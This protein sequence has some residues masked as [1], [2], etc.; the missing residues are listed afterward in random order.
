MK[1]LI[2]VAI[3]SIALVSAP[4]VSAQAFSTTPGT[5][6][7]DST[8]VDVQKGGG[9]Q[10]TCNL[11]ID[12]TR[13]ALGNVTAG[14]PVMTGGFF[15]L[16]TTVVFQNTPWTV[17]N[18]GPNVWRLSGIYVDTT[19]TAGDC[20]GYLDATFAIIGGKETLSVDTGF[21]PPPPPAAPSTLPEVDPGTG[22]CKIRGILDN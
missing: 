6:T 3:A 10:L 15:N 16:C 11:S 1:K 19:V 4:S 2:S 8:N 14:N 7:F 21:T 18:V 5:Y 13:D 20:S 9:L 17:T 22:Y 12:V